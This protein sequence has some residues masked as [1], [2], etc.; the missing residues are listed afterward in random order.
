MKKYLL[1]SIVV[2][3]IVLTSCSLY[4]GK[5]AYET[6]DKSIELVVYEN[7]KFEISFK[8]DKGA[9][10]KKYGFWNGGTHQDILTLFIDSEEKGKLGSKL[11]F[12]LSKNRD[13]LVQVECGSSPI[14][15]IDN[16]IV[17]EKCN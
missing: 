13:K 16:G 14:R 8:N 12:D 15:T 17:M 5:Y 11:C 1:L 6:K 7:N 10:D 3:S 4:G 2:I 9:I